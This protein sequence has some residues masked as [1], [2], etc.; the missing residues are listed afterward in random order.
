[1]KSPEFKD[2]AGAY[3]GN[4]E[5]DDRK[6][7]RGSDH[8]SDPRDRSP[9]Y[10]HSRSPRRHSNYRDKS[11]SNSH[12]RNSHRG[13]ERSI[14][15]KN[16]KD[17]KDDDDRHPDDNRRHPDDDDRHPD[18]DRDRHH[19]DD[20]QYDDD[21][22]H[23]DD[24]DVADH[25]SDKKVEKDAGGASHLDNHQNVDDGVAKNPEKELEKE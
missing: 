20:R 21:R 4:R 8:G 2:D 6:D 19:D 5:Y 24:R 7:D 18:D 3:R 13:S 12:G 14:V 22:H 17:Y 9:N 11:R 15:E 16:G 25:H 10:R 1:M 23:D